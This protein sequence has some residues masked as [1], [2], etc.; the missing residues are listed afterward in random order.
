MGDFSDLIT[1]LTILFLGLG[2]V[3]EIKY[4]TGR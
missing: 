2:I 1:L 3:C 4:L